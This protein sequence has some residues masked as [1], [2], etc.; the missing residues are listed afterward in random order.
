MNLGKEMRMRRI[1]KKG[2]TII[3][4]IDH[5]LYTEP[6]Q[7]LKDLKELVRLTADSKA[8]AILITP[9]MLRYVS[10]AVGNLGIILRIGETL[11]RLGKH[12]EKT[13][14]ATSVEYA[15]SMGADAVAMNV[16]V[17]VENEDEHLEKAGKTAVECHK[18]GMPLIAEMIPASLLSYHFGK[19]KKKVKNVDKDL[20]LVSR[21]AAELG[22]DVVKTQYSGNLNDYKEVVGST[23]LPIVIAG[24]PKVNTD[25]EF[26][27]MVSD[28]MTAGAKGMC[29]GRNVW[30]RKDPRCILAALNAI[31]HENKSAAAAEQYL[32]G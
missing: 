19:T 21:L 24:G 31:V 17:G 28:C 30:G 9:G 29:I 26:L 12:L 20:A 3:V 22:V 14:I 16:F 11:T 23:P 1:F 25:K 32:R 2:K 10:D 5:G 27:E 8:N 18:Y 4:P 7:P 6:P 13:K 15:A